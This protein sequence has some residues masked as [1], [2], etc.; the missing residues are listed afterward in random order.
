MHS[1]NTLKIEPRV[2]QVTN[3]KGDTLIQLTVSDAK[4]L[5]NDVLQKQVCDS[6]VIKLNQLDG[7][8]TVT[9]KL[10]QEK[11]ITLENKFSNSN[12]MVI[13]L[14]TIIKNKESEITSLND[15]IKHQNREILKQKIFKFLGFGAAILIPTSYLIIHK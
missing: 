10:Q 3:A 11:I 9:I 1:Q 7:L 14:E 2:K 13:N 12:T 4:I 8:R 5:L 15:I 6:T